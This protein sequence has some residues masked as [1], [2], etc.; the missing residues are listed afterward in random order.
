VIQSK[1]LIITIPPENPAPAPS[2][3]EAQVP[4]LTEDVAKPANYL[5]V[6]SEIKPQ[7]VGD[8]A[9][10]GGYTVI[11]SEA[12][13]TKPTVPPSSPS[14]PTVVIPA[15]KAMDE[16]SSFQIGDVLIIVVRVQTAPSSEV[17]P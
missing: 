15:G 1:P 9:V 16:V 2:M 4:P 12:A 6:E 11:E 13:D 17:E 10:P 7:V 8:V 14:V 5:V 3:S